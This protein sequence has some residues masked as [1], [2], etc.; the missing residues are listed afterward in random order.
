M[1]GVQQLCAERKAM[2]LIPFYMELGWLPSVK[3]RAV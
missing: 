2:D 1:R 3:I